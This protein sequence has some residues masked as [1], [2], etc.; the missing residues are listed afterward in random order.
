MTMAEDWRATLYV[1]RQAPLLVAGLILIGCSGAFSF[2]LLLRL[3]QAGDRSY[4]GSMWV[5]IPRTYLRHVRQDGWS[6][7]PLRMTWVCLLVGVGCIALGLF[8][9]V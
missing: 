8:A 1:L 9:W 6:V 2:H 4:G 3:E 5:T 7:W